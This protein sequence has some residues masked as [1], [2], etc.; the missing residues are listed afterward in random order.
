MGRNAYIV[1]H[2]HGGVFSDAVALPMRLFD[3]DCHWMDGVFHVSRAISMPLRRLMAEGEDD[4]A[5]FTALRKLAVSRMLAASLNPSSPPSGASFAE[6]NERSLIDNFPSF[7]IP[8][9][10]TSRKAAVERLR[11][12]GEDELSG[13]LGTGDSESLDA[14]LLRLAAALMKDDGRRMSEDEAAA[15]LLDFYGNPELVAQLKE[16]RDME[17]TGGDLDTV[18]SA[19]FY[20]RALAAGNAEDD[21]DEFRFVFVNYHEGLVGLSDLPPGV[22]YMADMPISTIP[23]LPG[24][25]RILAENGIKLA[26]YEDH[27]PYAPKHA[28]MLEKLREEEL[29]GFYAMSGPLVDS[30]GDALFEAELSENELKCGADMVYEALVA[31]TSADSPAME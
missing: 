13:L 29:V 4:N 26:R 21:I 18:S 5:F 3:F 30:S 14:L 15:S 7:A 6:F 28:E 11:K 8:F 1:I 31:G 22:L 20:A 12:E 9:G 23:D 10:H 25:L 16:L 17:E 2:G 27:H 24:D 19:V